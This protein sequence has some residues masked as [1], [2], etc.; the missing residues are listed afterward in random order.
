MDSIIG[1]TVCVQLGILCADIEKTAKAWG[2]FFG[3]EYTIK[4]SSPQ[5]IGH[6]RYEGEPTDAICRQ[7]FFE[8]G[9]IQIELIEP[10]MHPSVWRQDLDEKGEGLHH[11]AFRV[12]DTDGQLRKMEDMGMR[13]RQ[14]GGWPGGRYAYVDA[15]GQLAVLLETLEDLGK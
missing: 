5:A 15:M 13:T 3:M 9:N 1:T 2:D 6:A 10:D 8:M 11:I 12:K 4:E 7:A 14:T